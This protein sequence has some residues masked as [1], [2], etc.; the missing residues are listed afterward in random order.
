MNFKLDSYRPTDRH[1]CESTGTQNQ[2]LVIPV[3][4]KLLRLNEV[5][6]HQTR[7][8]YTV[9]YRHYIS[10]HIKDNTVPRKSQQEEEEKKTTN[11]QP[12]KKKRDGSRDSH[13]QQ[14]SMEGW[15]DN[16]RLQLCK[17]AYKHHWLVFFI[18]F[19]ISKPTT[20]RKKNQKEYIPTTI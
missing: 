16:H 2:H 13:T 20:E 8:P 1:R 19:Y 6:I 14:R 17:L 18:F 11:K 9:V 4:L 10:K 7:F 3:N 15:S 12:R 5:L